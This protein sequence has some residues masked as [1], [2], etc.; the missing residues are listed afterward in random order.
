MKKV[1]A[2]RQA[3][4]QLSP[5]SNRI[6][7]VLVFGTFDGL[8][9]G[10]LD[11]LRQAK[12]QGGY[13]TAVTALDETVKAVKGHYPKH[14]EQERSGALIGSGLVDKAFL[15]NRDDPYEIIRQIKPDI[16][17][18]GYDQKVF[19]GELPAALKKAGLDITIIRLKPYRPE[20]Y[21]SAILNA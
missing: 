6:K 21:H 2:L 3:Q 19:T 9:P 11:F 18:L 20:H 16:I 1:L 15:G 8:H 13:L 7:R 17:C 12:K 4:D 10:H 5:K 14:N